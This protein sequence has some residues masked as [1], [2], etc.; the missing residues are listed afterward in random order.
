VAKY[1]GTSWSELGGTNALS[2]NNTINTLCA[3]L[4]GNIYTAGDFT[5]SNGKKYV[6]KY[7]GTAWAELGGNNS[8]AANS[9]IKSVY[10]DL[11]GNIY[12]GGSFTNASTTKYVAQYN[13]TAWAEL[14]G[15][16][17]LAAN[18][19][20]NSII[21][22]AT[23]HIYAAGDFTNANTKQYV[24]TFHYVAPCIPTSS[25]ISK[26][27]CNGNSYN[28]NG[29]IITHSG[30]Y[31]DTV[32]NYHGCDSVITLHVSTYIFMTS[33]SIS[34][35]SIICTTPGVQYQWI[36]C[37]TNLPIAGATARYYI[38]TVTGVYKVAAIN[39]TCTDTSSCYTVI[40][41]GMGDLQLQSGKLNV[42]PNPTNDF[43][44]VQLADHK[45]IKAITIIDMLGREMMTIQNESAAKIFT[46]DTHDLSSGMYMLKA[47]SLMGEMNITRFVKE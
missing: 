46:I 27:L 7:N 41:S 35:D 21:T 11:A 25:S 31:K 32:L 10:P 43:L 40:I 44:S 6:A 39:G 30:T 13:G 45:N 15:L 28:F 9:S 19:G 47:E 38:P 12:A 29:K 17:S 8:L 23:S 34:G 26:N 5:N 20:I 3:D 33:Y 42:F 24:A 16:N 1:N 4:S 14:G 36:N 18:G 2:P 37:V 22:D